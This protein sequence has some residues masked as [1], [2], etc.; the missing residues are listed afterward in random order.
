MACPVATPSIVPSAAAAVVS[1]AGST[2]R[3]GPV[4]P[5][6]TGAG[7]EEQRKDDSRHKPAL[8]NDMHRFHV[9]VILNIARE[10]T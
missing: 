7:K 3:R 2:V 1:G 8:Y 10:N 5:L 9:L 4:S 6:P